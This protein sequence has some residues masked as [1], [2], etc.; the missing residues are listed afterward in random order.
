M[1]NRRKR[2]SGQIKRQVG[3]ER[4][5]GQRWK[6]SIRHLLL[7]LL[8]ITLWVTAAGDGFIGSEP[9]RWIMLDNGLIYLW[10]DEWPLSK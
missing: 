2:L 5:P 4:M 8:V 10:E 6:M 1:G 7:A 9:K 3:S